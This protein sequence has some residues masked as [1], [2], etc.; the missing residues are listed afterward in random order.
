[1]SDIFNPKLRVKFLRTNTINELKPNP[2]SLIVD[3]EKGKVYL[4]ILSVDNTSKRLNLS[5][6]IAWKGSV[7][8]YNDLPDDAENGDMYNVEDTGANYI[9]SELD[10]AWDKLSEDVTGFAYD[11]AVVHNTNAENVGGLKTFTDGI[12]LGSGAT[13]SLGANATATTKNASDNS[14]S[15]ATTAFVKNVVSGKQDTISDID[16]IR[17]NASNGASA[18][19]IISSYGD[20]VTHNASEFMSSSVDIPIITDIYNSSSHDGMSGVAVASALSGK[21]DIISDIETI[22]N[23]ASAGANAS[24]TIASYGDIVMH[25]ASEFMS[26]SASF[27]TVTDTYSATSHDGMSGIAVASAISGKQDTI[28]DIETIRTNASS[29]ASAASIISS[30]GDIVTHNASEFI[31]SIPTASDSTSGT[32]KL[33]TTSGS[34]TDGTYTQAYITSNYVTGSNL[35]D[36]IDAI[37]NAV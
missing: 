21:Q 28:S 17:N 18:Y 32:T 15:V 29:G 8:T 33:Y 20:V 1:M 19:T 2:G 10:N 22:R 27:P 6:G 7:P 5:G 26:S 23:N 16:T 37:N 36:L 31:T 3:M 25:N 24:S 11:S 35:E 34:N 13:A 12:A 14:T 9:W 30:Y 4:D